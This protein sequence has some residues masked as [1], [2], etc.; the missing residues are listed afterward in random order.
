MGAPWLL[1]RALYGGPDSGR[2]WY[3][4]YAH[5]M[6][7]GETICPFQRCH[8]EPCTFVS[9][10]DGDAQPPVRIICS[11]YVDDGRTWD[12]CASDCDGFLHRL[13]QRFSI[14][15]D[16]GGLTYMIGMEIALGVRMTINIDSQ[17]SNCF[18]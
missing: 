8:F 6:M 2:L 16:G 9:V 3:N 7:K 17:L 18:Y 1:R 5:Y 15:M 10:I 11:V 14:T 13:S 12:N 4:T